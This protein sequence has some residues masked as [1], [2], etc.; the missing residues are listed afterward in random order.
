MKGR[1]RSSQE[2]REYL[3]RNEGHIKSGSSFGRLKRSYWAA[4]TLDVNVEVRK[5]FADY[6]R[7]KSIKER[8]GKLLCNYTLA[9]SREHGLTCTVGFLLRV[10]GSEVNAVL[11]KNEAC[12]EYDVIGIFPHP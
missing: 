4:T 12:G 2:V 10:S 3:T 6:Q 11:Y 1:K 7:C 8:N 5:F 9:G